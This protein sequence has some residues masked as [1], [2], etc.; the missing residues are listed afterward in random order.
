MLTA[1]AFT[2]VLGGT[3]LDQ[4]AVITAAPPRPQP[5][6]TA[7]PAA[8]TVRVCR[9]ETPT[10]SNR[11]RRVC[12]DIPRQGVQDQQT[13]EFMRDRQRYTPDPAG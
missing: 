13:R 10:G 8:G 12:R 1:L 3:G 11:Q 9:W 7:E 6:T 2:L 5:A 4:V